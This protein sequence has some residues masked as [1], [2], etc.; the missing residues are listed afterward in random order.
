M[1]DNTMDV[2]MKVNK[3]VW[4]ESM[5]N[6]MDRRKVSKPSPVTPVTN[7]ASHL[8]KI[9]IGRSVLDVGCGSMEVKRLLPNSVKYVG[10]DPFPVNEEVVPGMIEKDGIEELFSNIDTVLCFAVMDGCMDFEKAC[11]NIKKIALV[12][13]VFLTGIGIEP[14]K[15]HT[16]KLELS[17]Y[18]KEF[19]GWKETRCDRI[20]DLV[21]LLEYT[22]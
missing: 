22:R 17:D 10:L 2:P 4:L 15:F 6:L 20:S 21:Y 19:S 5:R 8:S 11:E 16:L 18:R 13:V 12:N 3:I 14:D 7:Y 1:G 9:H